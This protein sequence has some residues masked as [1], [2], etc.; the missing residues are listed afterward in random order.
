MSAN[1]QIEFSK[2]KGNLH[3]SPRGDFDGNSAWELVNLIHEQYDGKGR[4]YIE[5]SHLL[6]MHPFGCSTFQCRLDHHNLP[7]DQLFFKGEKGYELAPKGCKI[8]SSNRKHKCNCS[9]DC[10]NCK[11]A[12]KKLSN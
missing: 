3:V 11:C 4:V 10:S 5:T 12:A 2:D 7:F 9:G 8:V 6:K 1:F